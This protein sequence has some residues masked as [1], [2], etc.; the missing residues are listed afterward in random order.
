MDTGFTILNLALA[1]VVLTGILGLSVWAIR[2]S[3]RAEAA[4]ARSRSRG[5][6]Q[7]PRPRTAVPAGTGSRRSGR[8][9]TA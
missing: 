5:R 8:A 6:G 3:S 7:A 4:V 2:T 1:L 9:V